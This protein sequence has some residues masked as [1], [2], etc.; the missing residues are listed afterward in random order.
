MTHAAWCRNGRP[1]GRCRSSWCA[2]RTADHLAAR[3]TGL[4]K[5][6][7][8][9]VA[10]LDADDVIEPEHLARLERAF[11]V[12]ADLSF[13][14]G[15]SRITTPDGEEVGR[16]PRPGLRPCRGAVPRR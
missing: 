8:D 11:E 6:R 13:A 7:T 14:F 3:N 4:T 5:I 15:I 2:K 1:P 9:L 12:Y 16:F 10:F